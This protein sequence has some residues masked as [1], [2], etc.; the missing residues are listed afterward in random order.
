M[1]FLFKQKTKYEMRISDWSSDVCSSDLEHA[2]VGHEHV[3]EDHEAVGHVELRGGW[4]VPG[5]LAAG[6]VGRVDDLHA[7]GVHRHRA[8]DEIGRASGRARVCQ[9]V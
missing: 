3:V 7:L 8:G 4:E 5:V 9:Y 2:L 1:L 6:C